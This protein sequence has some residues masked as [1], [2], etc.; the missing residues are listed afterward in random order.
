MKRN[1]RGR[2]TQL[3]P[4][5]AAR[6]V[7]PERSDTGARLA[8]ERAWLEAGLALLAPKEREAFVLRDLEGLDTKDVAKALGST[9]MTVRSQISRARCK[10]KAFH[11][12]YFGEVR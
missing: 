8:E 12:V 1:Q 10:L 11:A 3:S 2:T 4:D 6:L 5:E 7:A 9:Q